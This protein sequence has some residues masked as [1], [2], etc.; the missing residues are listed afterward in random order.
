[1]VTVV[2][3]ALALQACE[4]RSISNSGYGAGA[5]GDQYARGRDNPFYQGELSEFD[6]LAAAAKAVA[7]RYGQ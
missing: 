6:I 2:T 4:T 5:G 3:L 1:M 7:A